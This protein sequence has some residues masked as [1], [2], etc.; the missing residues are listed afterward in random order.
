MRESGD[1][2]NDTFKKFRDWLDK[3]YALG[4]PSSEEWEIIIR[5]DED[6]QY[7]SVETSHAGFN[8]E[9]QSGDSGTGEFPPGPGEFPP[10]PGEFPP[11]EFQPEP[12]DF[13]C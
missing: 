2:A 13:L 7:N 9:F 11:G 10:G 6:H 8:G 3:T 4:C 1:A 12:G 5:D